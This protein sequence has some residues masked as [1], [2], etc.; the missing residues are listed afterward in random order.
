MAAQPIE[1]L[2][3]RLAS[4]RLN[5]GTIDLR[6]ATTPTVAICVLDAARAPVDLATYTALLRAY[7]SAGAPIFDAKTATAGSVSN[8]AIFAFALEET[9]PFA[10]GAY[11]CEIDLVAED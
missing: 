4:G 3:C 2:T 1:T 11:Y 6:K 9:T 8:E 5:V 10:G 7:D